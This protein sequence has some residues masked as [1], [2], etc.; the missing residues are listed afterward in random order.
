MQDH[1]GHL[2]SFQVA[3]TSSRGHEVV[4]GS[5]CYAGVAVEVFGQALPTGRQYA[6]RHL[7][8]EEA[9]LQVGGEP[10]RRAVQSLK[11]QGMKREPGF[12]RLLHLPGDPYEALLMLEGKSLAELAVQLAQCPCRTWVNRRD[13][14]QNCVIH[15]TPSH[16]L[17]GSVAKATPVKLLLSQAGN[18]QVDEGAWQHAGVVQA[19]P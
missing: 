5:F 3:R 17:L 9:I 7:V 16:L 6:F 4:V 13:G 19:L 12:A 18:A 1:Y 2:P 15:A 14:T 8:V 10:W 11:Q